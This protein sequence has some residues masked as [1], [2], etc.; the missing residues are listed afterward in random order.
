MTT[1]ED[2]D[3]AT[4]EAETPIVL[5]QLVQAFY[6]MCFRADVGS[7]AHDFVPRAHFFRVTRS[8]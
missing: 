5:L 8:P 6:G 7:R 1:D 2:F 3:A 4:W